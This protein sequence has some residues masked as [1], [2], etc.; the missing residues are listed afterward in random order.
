M[1]NRINPFH[2]LYLSEAIGADRFVHLFSPLFVDH[3]TALFQPGH[4]VLQGLQGSGKTM[5]LNLL[6]PDTRI[7]YHRSGQ[8]FPVKKLLGK[9]IGTGINLRKAGLIEFGQL[10]LPESSTKDLTQLALQYGDFLNY[11]V[12]ADLLSTLQKF[13]AED[14]TLKSQIGLN[15]APEKLDQLAKRFSQESCFFGY[16]ESCNNYTSLCSRVRERILT[17]RKYINL[18]LKNGLPETIQTTVSVIGEPI[19]RLSGTLK[20]LEILDSDTEVYVRVDQYE[21]LATL[22]T[23]ESSFGDFCK[24][25]IVWGTEV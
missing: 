5:L 19:S 23:V 12:I 17:Y 1:A 10:A 21:Q 14:Q 22:N 18:N 7:A 13:A 8:S 25:D 6:K 11:W 16:L 3:A 24:L 15:L 9:F 2:N 20:E 4:V